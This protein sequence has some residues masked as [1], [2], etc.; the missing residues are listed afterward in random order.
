MIYRISQIKLKPEEGTERIPEKIKDRLGRK[1]MVIKDHTIVKESVDA[2]NKEN[3]RLVYTVDFSCDD[4][5][6]L[7]VPPDTTYE[8]AVTKE[9]F[10]L[11]ERI[12]V[13]RPVIVGMGP[14]GMFAALYL[15]RMGFSPLLIERG[16]PVEDRV[17]DVKEFWETGNLD[18]ESNVRFGEGG[19]GTFSDGKLTTGIKDKR[20]RQ[21]LEELA[22]AGGGR[23]VLYKQKPH[24]GTDRLC[25]VVKAL[26]EE[27]IREGGEIWFSAR[28]EKLNILQGA[29]RSV[30]I[31]K[32]HDMEVVE[33]DDVVVA[34]G[35]GAADTV[36]ML[37]ESDVP[38]ERKPFSIGVRIEH[39]QE[40]I[41][42]AQYGDPKLA[43]R[44]G[45]AEY[46]LSYKAKNGRGVY[47]FC[48]CPGGEVIC[49]SCEKETVVTNGM[50]YHSRGGK[51]ANS[52]VLVDVRPEDMGTDDPI[53][54]FLF[55]ER[56]EK[57][58]Y[59]I[60]GGYEIPQVLWKD[61]RGSDVER[62][63]P[64]F[65][66]RAIEE[67]IP[68]F[69][70]KLKGFDDP[71]AVLKAVET[72]SSSPV[73]ILRGEDRQS[74]IKGLYPGGE[75]AGYAG[76]IVSAAVDGIRIAEAIAVKYRGRK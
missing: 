17:R 68:Y 35:H 55:R 59:D 6:D 69:G 32:G 72:G 40:A 9:N 30:E 76:G 47:T 13:H 39:L 50:S 11:M 48:M 31:R 15:A 44:L 66:A 14:C 53:S 42:K 20:V 28:L 49:S 60:S 3:I 57:A 8:Y 1:D 5:L 16:K 33:T 63:L 74:K 12:P 27:I 58:A 7:P 71:R 36:K 67:A 46:K 51:Y 52:G 54:G 43:K 24:I 25:I 19:A 4:E 21:V 29:V 22:Q 38:M 45:P 23:E 37:K 64:D 61:F 70:K 65:A 41:D 75:G 73:R 26:R 62:C 56:F 10:H 18:E 34:I 2:R